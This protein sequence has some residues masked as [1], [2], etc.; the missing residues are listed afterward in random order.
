MGF[1]GGLWGFYGVLWGSD[2]SFAGFMGFGGFGGEYR[3]GYG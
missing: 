1:Y 3:V 2:R